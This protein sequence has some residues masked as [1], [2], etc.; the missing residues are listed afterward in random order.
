[1]HDSAESPRDWA[2]SSS[3]VAADG[4]FDTLGVERPI[5]FRHYFT[6][7]SVNKACC[8]AWGALRGMGM[9][10][11]YDAIEVKNLCP[12]VPRAQ[13][14]YIMVDWHNLLAD[15]MT[16]RQV[17]S[18]GINSRGPHY[19]LDAPLEMLIFVVILFQGNVIGTSQDNTAA[20][21]CR[22]FVRCCLQQLGFRLA[23]ALNPCPL[24]HNPPHK[25]SQT[26]A[27]SIRMEGNGSWILGLLSLFGS[28]FFM[29]E[30]VTEF[31]MTL[32]FVV[33]L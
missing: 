8:S 15:M 26:K 29:F 28:F 13:L 9:H 10:L 23:N 6:S 30:W 5:L 21:E 17:V 14:L 32:C 24:G 27:W 12:T 19:A 20:A 16:G 33:F 4:W 25:T 31:R 11:C 7:S 18:M 3:V 22:W 2:V 1:M